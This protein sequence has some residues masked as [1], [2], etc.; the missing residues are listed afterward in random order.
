MQLPLKS[1][2]YTL[3]AALTGYGGSRGNNPADRRKM[4]TGGAEARGI[5]PTLPYSI[6]KN[7]FCS[8]QSAGSP[9]FNAASDTWS[10]NAPMI[11]R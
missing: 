2:F 11:A 7:F 3:F 1:R 8:S 9:T 5:L 10:G 4:R 6:L